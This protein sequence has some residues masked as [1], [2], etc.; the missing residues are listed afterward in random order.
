ML[1]QNTLLNNV[2]ATITFRRK[3]FVGQTR[4]SRG[5][6]E[7]AFHRILGGGVLLPLTGGSVCGDLFWT[8]SQ[9]VEFEKTAHGTSWRFWGYFKIEGGKVF[10]FSRRKEMSPRQPYSQESTLIDL[11]RA[12]LCVP[13]SGLPF[14]HPLY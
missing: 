13:C 10:S 3:Y 11:G 9:M 8:D 12:I 2:L 4:I 14:E 1:I 6:I 7:N 5:P